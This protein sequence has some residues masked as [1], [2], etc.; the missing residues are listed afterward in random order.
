MT[1]L[2][3]FFFLIILC[4][5]SKH[6]HLTMHVFGVM[7]RASTLKELN[8]V[9]IS[10]NVVFSSSHSGQNVEKHFKNLQILL[11]KAGPCAEDT[12][13]KEENYEVSFP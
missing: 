7:T 5:A 6:Y 4:S 12:S 3:M 11:T 9:V 1:S 10:A 8:E 13:I 2:I